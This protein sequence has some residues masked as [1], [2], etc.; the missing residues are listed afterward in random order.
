[1]RSSLGF[2]IPTCSAGA[3]ASRTPTSAAAVDAANAN[4]TKTV[5]KIHRVITVSS[6]C[7]PDR[8]G[9][10]GPQSKLYALACRSTIVSFDRA[11]EL[12]AGRGI[13]MSANAAAAPAAFRK[14]CQPRR[15]V[16]PLSTNHRHDYL[17]WGSEWF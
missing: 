2:D 14:P 11:A 15:R 12:A 17:L 13:A 3:P 7:V 8:R 16:N 10:A 9:P 4:A 5:L 6:H 1:M